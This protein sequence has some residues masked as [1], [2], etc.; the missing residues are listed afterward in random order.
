MRTTLNAVLERNDEYKKFKEDY[1]KN[2][3][4]KL[5]QSI[6]K[7]ANERGQQLRNE[8]DV[9][10]LSLKVLLDLEIGYIIYLIDQKSKRWNRL[11][12]EIEKVKA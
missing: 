2:Y 7:L 3:Q 9:V 5:E 4:G 10:T 1:F 12:S 6:Q 11:M 8:Q